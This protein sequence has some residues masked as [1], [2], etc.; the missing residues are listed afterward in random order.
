M[1]SCHFAAS[2]HTASLEAFLFFGPP[3]SK[4][5][6]AGETYRFPAADQITLIPKNS[7]RSVR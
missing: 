3:K 6:F 2:A 4:R 5:L 1:V 7:I